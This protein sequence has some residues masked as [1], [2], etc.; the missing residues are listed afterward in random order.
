VTADNNVVLV[1]RALVA[2]LTVGELELLE[3]RTG[4]PLSRLFDADAPRGTLL[5]CL[6]F[7]V[8]RRE[9]PSATWEAA[10]DARVELA[11]DADAEVSGATAD[12]TRGGRGR[13]RG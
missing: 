4:R 5:R 9:D 2:S 10:G 6:A 3:D 8:Q 1:D 13:S 7:I 11:A 12:P